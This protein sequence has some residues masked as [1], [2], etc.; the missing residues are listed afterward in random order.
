[1]RQ[2]RHTL[3]ALLTLGVLALACTPAASPARPAPPAAPAPGGAPAPAA[4]PATGGAPPVLHK[5]AAAYSS[6]SGSQMP[7][8]LAV[9][10]GLFAKHGLEVEATYIAS[11]TTALQSLLA[12]EIQFTAGSGGEPTA[13]YLNGAPAQILLGWINTFPNLFMVDPSI[14]S[15]EQLRG[16]PIGISRFGGQPHVAA[17]LALKKWGLNPDSDVQYLQ[18][19]GVPE[20][21]A[22]MQS[23]A[24]VGGVFTPPTNVRARQLGYRVLGDLGQMGIPFQGTVLIGMQPYVEAN[25]DITK[26]FLRAILEGIHLYLTDDAASRAALAKYTRT[27]DVEL[28]DE[29]NNYYRAIVE[30]RPYPTLD[31]LQ[32]ILDDLADSDPR[33]R[34]IR[35]EQIVNT[36]PLEEIEREG[37]LKQLYGE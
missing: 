17:R 16:K 25:P 37:F 13:A 18:L 2:H 19:G 14:T 11:G 32:T 27:E 6:L 8:Y 33:A 31:G 21:L 7:I 23:G 20:I 26:R 34:V 24:V 30:R 28:L 4:Q 5:V 35:P 29:S 1:M 15:P 36:R 10:N 3:C 22:G 9:E 12:N